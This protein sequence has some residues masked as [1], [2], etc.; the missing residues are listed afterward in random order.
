M[1]SYR[2]SVDRAPSATL[3]AAMLM[4]PEPIAACRPDGTS[5]FAEGTID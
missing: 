3:P 4:R 2:R 5:H 1:W